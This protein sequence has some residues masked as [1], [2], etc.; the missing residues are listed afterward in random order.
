[1]FKDIKQKLL[2]KIIENLLNIWIAYVM[3]FILA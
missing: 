2:T 3:N 1:M